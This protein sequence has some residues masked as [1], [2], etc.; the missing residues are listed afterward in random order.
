MR[1]MPPG[2]ASRVARMPSQRTSFS[3]SV[4][5]ENTISG[6]AAIYRS[7]ST[8]SSSGAVMGSGSPF[9]S[10]R[11]LLQAL[12][13]LIPKAVQKTPQFSKTFWVSTIKPLRSFAAH[14]HQIGSHEDL[15]VLGNSWTGQREMRRDVA[16]RAF[17]TA[18]KQQDLSTVWFGKG[19]YDAV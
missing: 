12:Q 7:R 18:K 8:I 9:F 14:G 16:R 17:R 10:F 4:K 5:K 13:M 2:C 11:L 3:G 1:Q 6:R 15:Q 19:L